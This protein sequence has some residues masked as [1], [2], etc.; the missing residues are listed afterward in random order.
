MGSHEDGSVS[1]SRMLPSSWSSSCAAMSQTAEKDGA[2]ARD[3][4][5]G[6]RRTAHDPFAGSAY[7]AGEVHS[8]L[9]SYPGSMVYQGGFRRFCG[10]C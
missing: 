9:T 2:S 4:E 5:V 6:G 1:S 7:M 3:V 8:L 10:E